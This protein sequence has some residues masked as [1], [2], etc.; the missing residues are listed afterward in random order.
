MT[1]FSKQ[2]LAESSNISYNALTICI[3]ATYDIL[4]SFK[5]PGL[6]VKIT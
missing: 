2:K 5:T 1:F 3:K 6:S 4:T